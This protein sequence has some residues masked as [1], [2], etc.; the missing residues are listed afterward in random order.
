MNNQLGSYSFTT[1]NDS[2]S[3]TQFDWRTVNA[4]T[5]IKNQGMCGSS[6]AFSTIAFFEQ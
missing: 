5:A 3:I 1:N 6:W 2:T 4:F